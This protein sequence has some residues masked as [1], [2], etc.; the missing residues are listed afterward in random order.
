MTMQQ[1]RFQP[2]T[3]ASLAISMMV[4]AT[5]ALARAPAKPPCEFHF[6][7]DGL[8]PGGTPAHTCRGQSVRRGV[9]R[10]PG[11][12]P[13]AASSSAYSRTAK[14]GRHRNGIA[15]ARGLRCGFRDT[16]GTT[17]CGTAFTAG[18]TARVQTVLSPKPAR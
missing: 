17:Q 8:A 12:V 6:I 18:R 9:D 4:P 1:P 14:D 3:P 10:S 16:D 5:A 7:A 2:I 15:G 11:A 13:A